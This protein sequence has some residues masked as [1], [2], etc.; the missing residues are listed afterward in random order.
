MEWTNKG[1][2]LLPL[3]YSYFKP[4]Y[5]ESHLAPPRVCS[6]SIVCLH[7]SPKYGYVNV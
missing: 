6:H 7:I 1:H 3:Q 4:I 5:T 2:Q